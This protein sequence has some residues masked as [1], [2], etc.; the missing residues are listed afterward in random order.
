MKSRAGGIAG[1]DQVDD[2]AL[3]LEHRRVT[4]LAGTVDAHVEPVPVTSRTH[5]HVRIKEEVR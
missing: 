2:D 1:S 4:V 3:A 5:R